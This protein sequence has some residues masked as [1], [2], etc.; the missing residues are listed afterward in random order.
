MLP[1]SLLEEVAIMEKVNVRLPRGAIKVQRGKCQRGQS[2]GVGGIGIQ[3]SYL[4]KGPPLALLSG[5][6][7]HFDPM[8]SAAPLKWLRP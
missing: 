6:P 5:F 3:A 8:C 1:L 2:W 7:E 4:G